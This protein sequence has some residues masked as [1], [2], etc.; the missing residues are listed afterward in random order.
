MLY[1]MVEPQK[2]S[3]SGSKDNR[4]YNSICM[5]YPKKQIYIESRQL[6]SY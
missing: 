3:K 4:L 1:N 5:K 2:H 6:L